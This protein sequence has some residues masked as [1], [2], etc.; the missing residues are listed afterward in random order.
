MVIM[1]KCK[2]SAIMDEWCAE[3]AAED[4]DVVSAWDDVT[5]QRLDDVLGGRVVFVSQEE[6]NRRV[7]DALVK[8]KA[9]RAA[10]MLSV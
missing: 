4:V 2:K 3:T 8:V 10:G 5:M 1:D 7:E 6:S 9:I